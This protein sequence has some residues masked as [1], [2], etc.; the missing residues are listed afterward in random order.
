[1]GRQRKRKQHRRTSLRLAV[2]AALAEPACSTRK[3]AIEIQ[4]TRGSLFSIGH[5]HGLESCFTSLNQETVDSVKKSTE[6]RNKKNSRRS[7]M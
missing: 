6:G 4:K 3:I 2:C 7:Q 5:P 1:V